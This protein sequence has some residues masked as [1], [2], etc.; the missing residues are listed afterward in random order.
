MLVSG[1]PEALIIAVLNLP[2]KQTIGNVWIAGFTNGESFVLTSL[3]PGS[4]IRTARPSNVRCCSD[5][6][7]S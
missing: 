6:A 1:V 3:V 5:P 2:R 4:I 7:L